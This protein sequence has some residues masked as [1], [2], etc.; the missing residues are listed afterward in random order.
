MMCRFFVSLNQ[1]PYYFYTLVYFLF[2]L[3]SLFSSL[4]YIFLFCQ[5]KH[6]IVLVQTHTGSSLG[7]SVKN[8]SD[9]SDA[10]LA[11]TVSAYPQ[12]AGDADTPQVYATAVDYTPS[13]IAT[14]AVQ[15]NLAY[16]QPMTHQSVMISMRGV[17]LGAISDNLIAVVS[18]SRSVKCLAAVDAV[19]LL[20]FSIFAPLALVLLAGI[21]NFIL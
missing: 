20:L 3:S 21:S 6:I 2:S 19:I 1:Q 4:F 16:A 7:A 13:V 14:P 15:G 12:V 5:N 11:I 9:F 17:S 18:L 8:M 10:P